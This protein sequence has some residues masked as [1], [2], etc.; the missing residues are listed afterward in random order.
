MKTYSAHQISFI[1]WLGFWKKIYKS[2]FFDLSIYDQ[3]TEKTWINY[4]YIG[5]KKHKWG[6]K[7]DK[8]HYTSLQTSIVDINVE[9]NF[10]DD[11]LKDFY[12][13]HCNDKYFYCIYPLLKE[14]LYQV[15]SMNKLWLINFTLINII[16]EYLNIET[17]LVIMP[18][19]F[20]NPTQ[21]II[22]SVKSC[23]CNTYLSGPHGLNYLIEDSFKKNNIS[24]EYQKTINLY[25]K[26]P[27][28]IVS[29]LSQYGYNKVI[30]LLKSEDKYI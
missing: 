9:P 22:K 25:N 6:L 18:K 7:I 5:Q 14:W 12:K 21:D 17:K 29:L 23:N 2:N 15:N 4:T 26:Y 10:A 11:L 30:E 27:Q 8:N 19:L 20:N 16:K 3:Y 13:Y 28:S 24:I 1:P